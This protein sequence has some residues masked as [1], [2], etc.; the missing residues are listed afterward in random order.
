[1]SQETVQTNK[2][3][4]D[5]AGNILSDKELREISKNWN[6]ETWEQ[7]L[8]ETVEGSNSYL[9]EDLISPY[10]YNCAL[11]EMNES[12]WQ[13]SSSPESDDTCELV[14]RICRDG[15]TPKQ[16]YIIRMIFWDGFS[17]RKIAEVMNISRSTVV[18]QKKRGLNKIKDL[19]ETHQSNFRPY[20]RVIKHSPDQ[21]GS[22]FE[23]IQEVYLQE[24]SGIQFGTYGGRL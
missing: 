5:Q 8:V 3:W 11:E 23:D 4:L 10:S 24:V 18:V 7:F 12:I 6:S 14:R 15:L 13:C 19:L 21:K 1:M 22:R 17:E 2:S 9:R 20:E 16:Q